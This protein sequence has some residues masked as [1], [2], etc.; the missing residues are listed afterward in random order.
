VVVKTGDPIPSVAATRGEFRHLIEE[1]IG[2]AWR[3]EFSSFD[4]RTERPPH[5]RS[6]AAFVI[7]GSSANV[8]NR[9]AWMIETEAWLREVADTGTPVFGIC[10]GH[11]ILGQAL[12]GEVKKNPRGREI[13]TIR[14]ERLAEDP[15]FDG[16]PT[17]FE[18]NATHVDTVAA[19]P[20][21]AVVL[22]RSS[23]DDHQTVRFARSIYGVQ[24]HPE[25]DADV[26]RKYLDA[27][28]G[29]LADEGLDAEA[30][31]AAVTEARLA[32]ALLANFVRHVV[33][34]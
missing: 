20:R 19:L 28:R 15:I 30:I 25:I 26:M 21:G 10:F 22:A 23:L 2:A 14:V 13:G 24:F 12:G 32:R 8:P 18:A 9:E 7:T 3:G 11:Q 17:S 34:A 5:P 6:A 16:M 29:V 1:T 4:A 31:A 27:R 33:G